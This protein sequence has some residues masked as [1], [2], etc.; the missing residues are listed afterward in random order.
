MSKPYA[1][2][3]ICR[4]TG[5]GRSKK[6]K[7]LFT[8]PCW[9]RSEL[10]PGSLP[11]ITIL[12]DSFTQQTI[13]D[14]IIHLKSCD[15]NY[16]NNKLKGKEKKIRYYAHSIDYRG[17]FAKDDVIQLKA[18]KKK[19]VRTG[20]YQGRCYVKGINDQLWW[21]VEKVKQKFHAI[22]KYEKK[23]HLI[24]SIEPIS[25]TAWQ[26][27]ECREKLFEFR[28]PYKNASG[29]SI[30]EV[31]DG[32]YF[33]KKI[34]KQKLN[35]TK[36][37]THFLVAMN[38]K[39]RKQI[40]AKNCVL[41]LRHDVIALSE[42]KNREISNYSIKKDSEI[43]Y[44]CDFVY[45]IWQIEPEVFLGAQDLRLSIDQFNTRF[46]KNTFKPVSLDQLLVDYSPQESEA[47]S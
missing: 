11:G 23:Y 18:Q 26:M 47:K 32:E 27:I 37:R 29:I 33:R 38:E 43:Q 4:I 36:K 20:V 30:L 3:Q 19:D 6:D 22:K 9:I 8:R 14:N 13:Q 46:W 24:Y 21:I 39:K 7:D 5:T 12:I 35:I 2:V 10:P 1:V 17:F 15:R 40:E 45:A 44:I 41:Q 25:L 16:F 28:L 31:Q 42:R 34:K